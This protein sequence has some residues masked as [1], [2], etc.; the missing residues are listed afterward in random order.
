MT[1]RSGMPGTHRS[2]VPA[3]FF[4]AD[5]DADVVRLWPVAPVLV[6]SD[7]VG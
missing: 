2:A 7:G 1:S 4:D 5:A 3:G 6:A